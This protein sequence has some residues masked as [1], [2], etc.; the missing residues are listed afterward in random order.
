[1]GGGSNGLEGEANSSAPRSNGGDGGQEGGGE[2]SVK[3]R[4]GW[5]REGEVGRRRG[6][7]GGERVGGKISVG[8]IRVGGVRSQGEQRMLP[9]G[10]AVQKGPRREPSLELMVVM[11]RSQQV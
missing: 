10:Q 9:K 4:M 6:R 8:R 3:R 1:M 5:G 11:I 2:P 7:G